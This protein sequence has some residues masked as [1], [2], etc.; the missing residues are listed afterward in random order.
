M[1]LKDFEKVS[2]VKEAIVSALAR[3][4]L[5]LGKKIVKNPMKSL[6]IGFVGEESISAGTEA[7]KRLPKMKAMAR[8][9]PYYKQGLDQDI[10]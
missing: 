8:T 4:A 2:M 10:Y 3:G 9:N 6:G 1:N 5:G 7:A